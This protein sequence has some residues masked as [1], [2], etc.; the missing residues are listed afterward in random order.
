[1]MVSL[2]NVSTAIALTREVT[3]LLHGSRF[4]LTG[5]VSNS[6]ELLSSFLSDKL[7]KELKT[8]N[9][10]Y[11][12]LPHER[13][14]GVVCNV[15][16]DTLGFRIVMPDQPFTKRAAGENRSSLVRLA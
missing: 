13:A 8:V 4:V 3:N 9:V 2:D 11:E 12:K 7:S 10:E 5:F 1:M 16:N 15:E 6:R 14:L